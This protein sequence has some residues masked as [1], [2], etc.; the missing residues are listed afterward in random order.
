MS[1]IFS[2]SI[3]SFYL[4]L[5]LSVSNKSFGKSVGD[6]ANKSKTEVAAKD[7]K[8]Q[9]ATFRIG[10]HAYVKMKDGSEVE[11]V[12]K[13]IN[14]NKFWVSQYKSGRQGYV[15]KR[16]VRPINRKEKK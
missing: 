12:I 4:I 8:S 11:V 3:L 1:T 6:E 16:Y 14:K 13:G 9:S 5:A 7:A 10:Q 15:S 2:K